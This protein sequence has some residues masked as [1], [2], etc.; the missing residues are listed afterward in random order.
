MKDEILKDY[1][2]AELTVEAI[3]TKYKLSRK[4]LDKLL[5]TELTPIQLETRRKTKVIVSQPK[6]INLIGKRFGHL[7]ITDLKKTAKSIDGAYRSICKCDCGR[8]ADINTNY[9]IRGL[10]KTCGHLQCQFRRQDSN[11][12][13]V[14]NKYFSGYEEISGTK[15][16]HIRNGAKKRKIEFNISLEYVWDLFIKQ[17]RKCALTGREIYFGKT[18]TKETTASLDR[19]DSSKGYI[20][21][22]V[23]WVHKTLNVMKWGVSMGEF[24]TICKEVVKN[25]DNKKNNK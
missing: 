9:I 16:N 3:R 18:N 22:N 8:E 7:I 11:N 20:E 25:Y 21:G 13:G 12:N 15:F 17:E 10:Y 2:K 5:K 4:A 14:K 24:I 1:L 19:I 6:H 23:Q